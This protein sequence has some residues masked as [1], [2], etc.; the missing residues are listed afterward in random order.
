MKKNKVLIT[1]GAGFIGS[2]L[3]DA[4]IEKGY[5]VRILDNLEEQVHKGKTPSYLHNDA[6]FI[7][8][9]VRNPKTFEQ[10]LDGIDIVY[11]LAARVGVGQSNYEVKEY[12]NANIG[13][14]ATLFDVIINK[15]KPIKKVLMT[16]SMT[17]YG[18]GNYMCS[19]CGGVK[20]PLRE[21][22]QMQK[23]QWELFCPQCKNVLTPIPTTEEAQINNNSIYA[24]TKNVQEELLFTL[25]KMYSI[26]VVSFRCFN[27]YGPRQSLSNPYTGVTAIFI[28]RLKNN[29]PPV[30]YED[31]MQTRDFVSVHDVVNALLLGMEKKE[32]DYQIMNIGGG[33]P[34]P[35]KEVAQILA[36]LLKKDID[37]R[38][39]GEYRK[40]DIRNCYAD[41]T[42]AKKLLGWKP[43]VSLQQGF[44]ELIA[45]SEKEESED[46]FESAE[47][48]LR[49]KKLL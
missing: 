13:G 32:A 34:V 28:S 31:G 41:I 38:I 48:E 22:A 17:S 46:A 5:S 19:T 10:A 45:W 16:A 14:M 44:A 1:G 25:G 6:E 39:T 49:E 29:N 11:H 7:Q 23:E 3:T 30:V 27:V 21:D 2:F 15:K 43:H 20:P 24:L 8:G 26:P 42:K 37:P 35:I 4:L 40:N 12:V 47:K 36:K 9:D 33:K 18:E